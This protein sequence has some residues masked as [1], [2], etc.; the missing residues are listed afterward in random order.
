MK[1][2]RF[3]NLQLNYYLNCFPTVVWP[4]FKLIVLE[5]DCT[6]QDTTR[7][8]GS[9]VTAKT[10]STRGGKA[11]GTC[12]KGFAVCCLSKYKYFHF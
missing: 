8:Q 1:K 3:E 2:I 6:T 9:C 5:Q 12:A 7:P 10:C 4:F 11:S